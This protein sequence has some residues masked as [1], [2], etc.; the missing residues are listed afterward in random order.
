MYD[1]LYIDGCVFTPCLSTIIPDSVVLSLP[2]QRA[3]KMTTKTIE[4]MSPLDYLREIYTLA[5]NRLHDD[6]KNSNT[7]SL[8]Y[9]GLLST[10]DLED[11]DI[12]HVLDHGGKLLRDFLLTKSADKEGSESS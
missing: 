9:P 8:S 2:A 6:I 1:Q 4:S 7:V 11:F 5:I 10:S 12:P 3:I